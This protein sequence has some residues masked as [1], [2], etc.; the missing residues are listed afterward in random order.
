MRK[1][2]ACVVNESSLGWCNVRVAFETQSYGMFIAV[3]LCCI[4]FI[5]ASDSLCVRIYSRLWCN[6]FQSS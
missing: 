2:S 3:H 1:V 4:G 5:F 6:A